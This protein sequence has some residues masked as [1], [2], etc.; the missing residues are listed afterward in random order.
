ML[1]T[2]AILLADG[3]LVLVPV[4]YSLNDDIGAVTVETAIIIVLVK[5]QQQGTYHL[6][7]EDLKTSWVRGQ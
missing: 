2:S 7:I 4:Q 3:F 5:W 6:D 1:S